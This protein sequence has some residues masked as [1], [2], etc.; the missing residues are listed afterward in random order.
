MRILLIAIVAAAGAWRSLPDHEAQLVG[1]VCAP[2]DAY[3]TGFVSFVRYIVSS[4]TVESQESRDS[5]RVP[6]LDPTQ[7]V[8]VRS[9]SLCARAALLLNRES[10]R[11]DSTSIVVYM[12]SI[13]N[14]YWAEDKRLA[15]EWTKGLV[16]D[17][18]LTRILAR[19]GR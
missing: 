12:V 19:P 14:R 8:V 7:V 5:M 4:P 9:D 17:S 1:G 15:G 11:P 18:T 13:G 10:N 2:N 3:M 16:M 6:R